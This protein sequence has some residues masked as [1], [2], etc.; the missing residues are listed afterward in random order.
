MRGIDVSRYDQWPFKA[1]TEAAYQGSDFVIVKATDGVFYKHTDYFH[2]AITRALND[3]KLVGAYHYATGKDPEA[4]A[5]YFINIIHDYLGKIILALDWEEMYNS[6]WGSRTWAKKF[7]D[8]VRQRTGLICW[9]YTGMDG[10]DDCAAAAKTC[11]LWFAGYPTDANSW[12]VPRWPARYST[13][14]W[15]KYLLWQ[16]TSGGDKVDRNITTMTPAQWGAYTHAPSQAAEPVAKVYSGKWPALPARGY[17]RK[18]DGMGAFVDARDQVKRVQRLLNWMISADL[19]V[20]G[21]FGQKTEDAVIAAQK[22][23]GVAA[24]G[25]FGPKTLAAAKTYKK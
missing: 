20:D 23:L 14:P 13:E 15:D 17:F 8:R 1:D 12:T 4:E 24:D 25:M 22:T 18:G 21:K 11:P 6:Q 10:L 19:A 7:V 2:K 16:F 3:G 9:I 5:D